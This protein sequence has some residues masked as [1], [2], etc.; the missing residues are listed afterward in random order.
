MQGRRLGVDRFFDGSGGVI[1]VIGSIGLLGLVFLTVADVVWRYAL[2][3]PIFGLID[4][5]MMVSSAVVACSVTWAALK[6]AH[7]TIELIEGHFGVKSLLYLGRIIETLTALLFATACYAL[8]KKSTCGFACGDI[9]D[10][11]AIPHGPFYLA[12]AASMAFCAALSLWR[13]WRPHPTPVEE[14]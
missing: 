2:N 13:A 6:K 7:V 4:V 14:S 11:L 3:D 8:I 12:L 1:A 10:N 5:S 9:T